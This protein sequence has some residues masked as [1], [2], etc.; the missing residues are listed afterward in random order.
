MHVLRIAGVVDPDQE[1]AMRAGQLDPGAMLGSG[2]K[3]EQRGAE[4]REQAVRFRPL[5]F[6]ENVERSDTN[7][8]AE[9]PR[10]TQFG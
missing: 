5:V 9:L 6:P 8:A 7:V 2:E 10:K 1:I 3:M 4:V